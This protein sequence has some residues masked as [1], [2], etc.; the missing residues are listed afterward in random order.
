MKDVDIDSLFEAVRKALNEEVPAGW[1]IASCT[2]RDGMDY[3]EVQNQKDLDER[4][5]ISFVK[6]WR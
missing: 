4:F 6:G 5:I 3:L 1:D 2:T